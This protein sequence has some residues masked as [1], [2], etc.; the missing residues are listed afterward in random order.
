VSV[1]WG[2]LA[3]RAAPSATRRGPLVCERRPGLDRESYRKKSTASQIAAQ[4]PSDRSNTMVKDAP[5]DH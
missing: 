1:K 3:P 2:G 5:S 4:N